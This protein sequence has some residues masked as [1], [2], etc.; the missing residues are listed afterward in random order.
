MPNKTKKE[1]T[2]RMYR[3]GLGDCFLITFPRNPEPFHLLIDC[4]A[5]N[6]K[7]YGAELMKDVVRDIKI[8]T[9]GKIDAVVATHEHWDHISGFLQAEEIFRKIKVDKVWA[10]WTEEP[11]NES[12]K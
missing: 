2:I 4:G 5:L 8:K 3:Q 9:N 1:L 6:S 11:N 7:H 12:A 10:S